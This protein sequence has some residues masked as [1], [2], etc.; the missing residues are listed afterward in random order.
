MISHVPVIADSGI[1]LKKESDDTMN[2]KTKLPRKLCRV[3]LMPELGSSLGVRA[4]L[5]PE[6]VILWA[7]ALLRGWRDMA[8]ARMNGAGQS[9]TVAAG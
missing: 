1:L 6:M 7:G 4:S 8:D 5:H 3:L 9:G 2:V